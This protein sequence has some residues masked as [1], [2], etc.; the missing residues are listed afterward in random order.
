MVMNQIMILIDMDNT[1][2]SFKK[3]GDTELKK[4]PLLPE[5]GF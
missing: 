3:K 4:T 1:T 2:N 5:R